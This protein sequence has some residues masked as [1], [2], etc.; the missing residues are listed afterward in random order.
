MPTT[1]SGNLYTVQLVDQT[2]GGIAE[3]GT[4]TIKATTA[5]ILSG[6]SATLS[7][8][9]QIGKLSSIRFGF[10]VPLPLEAG[11]VIDVRF[12]PEFTEL[13]LNLKTIATTSIF[14]KDR[15]LPFS[16]LQSNQVRIKDACIFP[17]SPGRAFFEFSMVKNP[18]M[19][20][21]T[22]SSKVTIM[23][24]D[25]TVLAASV[26]P[27]KVSGFTP[28]PF[29]LFNASLSTPTVNSLSSLIVKILPS[30]ILYENSSIRLTFDPLLKLTS[31]VTCE[32]VNTVA[33]KLR[34]TCTVSSSNLLVIKDLFY[35]V[36]YD[37]NVDNAVE[38]KISGV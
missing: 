38:V 32:S 34:P 24:K 14:G 30:N 4:I 5:A 31:S 1:A 20:K 13:N 21:E 3:K 16:V 9:T 36:G 25:S 26:D 10:D 18:L 23:A 37:P 15:L 19:V 28:G 35:A 11:C 8:Q 6:G 2:S 7:G 12:A 22:G 33:T 17:V 29:K 27:I